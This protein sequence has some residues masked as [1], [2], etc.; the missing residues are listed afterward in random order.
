MILALHPGVLVA[1]AL[2]LALHPGVLGWI[3]ALYPGVLVARA[4]ILALHPG[5]QGGDHPG[6]FVERVVTHGWQIPA[7]HPRAMCQLMI[8]AVHRR[9]ML[10]IPRS[11]PRVMV[12]MR[13]QKPVQKLRA[14]M[15]SPGVLMLFVIP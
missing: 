1:R 5:V 7:L 15:T 10:P 6:V 9:P 13:N 11:H 12:M 8:L 3:L 14:R 4:L 2:I